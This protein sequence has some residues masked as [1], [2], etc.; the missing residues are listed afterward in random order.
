[1][2]NT[3]ISYNVNTEKSVFNLYDVQHPTQVEK[4]RSIKPYQS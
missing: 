4:K 1:M 2:E 3:D